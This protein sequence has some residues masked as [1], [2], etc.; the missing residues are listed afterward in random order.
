MANK[1]SKAF[2]IKERMRSFSHAMNGLKILLREEHNARIHLAV[3]IVVIVA[4]IF[5]GLSITEWIII[6]ILI[7][8]VFAM[9][10]VNS[11]IENLCDLICPEQNEKIKKIKDLAAS[12][13]FVAAMI[14]IIAGIVLF[15]SKIVQMLN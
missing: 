1:Q 4:G 10:I 12:A 13:V 8:F 2:S 14:S 9:E 3:A 5:V 7:G 11:A 6:T 15:L